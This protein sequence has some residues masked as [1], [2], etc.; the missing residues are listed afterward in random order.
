M[1]NWTCVEAFLLFDS[2]GCHIRPYR[3]IVIRINEKCLSDTRLWEDSELQIPT[4]DP[5][6]EIPSKYSEV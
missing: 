6:R 3:Y 4:K 5:Y 2:A 1:G